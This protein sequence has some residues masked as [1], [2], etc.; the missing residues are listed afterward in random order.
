METDMYNNDNENQIN[1]NDMMHYEDRSNSVH[2][3]LPATSAGG[4]GGQAWWA[5]RVESV[6]NGNKHAGNDD[7][8]WLQN[9]HDEAMKK[10]AVKTSPDNEETRELE[11]HGGWPGASRHEWTPDVD[12]V[13]RYDDDREFREMSPHD[14]WVLHETVDDRSAGQRS[15]ED[16][17]DYRKTANG[18]D[19]SVLSE[20]AT[21][22]LM[23]KNSLNDYATKDDSSMSSDNQQA[24]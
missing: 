9:R 20:P 19:Q 24:C 8:Q 14:N 21:E 6:V 4:D 3:M 13:T 12:H 22:Q 5:N 11:Q 17:K 15:A 16:Y 2:R 10:D 7:M 23:H 18:Y 1:N